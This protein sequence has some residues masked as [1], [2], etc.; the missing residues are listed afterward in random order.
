M[1]MP[2]RAVRPPPPAAEAL[3]ARVRTTGASALADERRRRSLPT[4]DLADR[5]RVSPASVNAVESGRAVSL[6]ILT[7]VASALGLDI[8]LK[9]GGRHRARRRDDRDVVHAAMG[10][11]EAGLLAG[12]DHRVAIDHPYQL[13]QFAGRADVL[14][15][16]TAR[17]SMLHI[18]NRTRFPNLQDTAGSFNAK[19]QY[20][21]SVLAKQLDTH[22]FRSQ[23]HV[24]VALWSSEVIHA[25]RLRPQSFRALCPDPPDPFEAWLA[26]N[27]PAEPGLVRT[28]VLLDPFARGRRRAWVGL[29]PVLSGVKP[30]MRGYAE[31]AARLDR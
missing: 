30:R 12:H 2:P 1:A 25:I 14:A 4:R 21:A 28:L 3:A 31:A 9:V 8:E 11:L 27:P 19:C 22:P 7:R 15:W 20:L 23:V 26:G 24:I 10:E 6:D 16:S 29:D 13:Y 17:R 18:E 5:A